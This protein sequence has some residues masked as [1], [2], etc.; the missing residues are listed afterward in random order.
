MKKDKITFYNRVKTYIYYKSGKDDLA[1]K[2]KEQ[3]EQFKDYSLAE[4][5]SYIDRTEF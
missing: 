2:Y 3:L 1:L 4:F 5:V